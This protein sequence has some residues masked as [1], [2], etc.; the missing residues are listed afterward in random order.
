MEPVNCLVTGIEQA[1]P[2][3]VRP[4]QWEDRFAVE[5]AVGHRKQLVE[6]MLQAVATSVTKSSAQIRAETRQ[7]RAI[8]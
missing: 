3:A 6:I 7:L 5:D 2:L 1:E 4:D 8:P